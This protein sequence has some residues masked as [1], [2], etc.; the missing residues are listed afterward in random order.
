[1][2]ISKV[3]NLTE[4]SFVNYTG[5][6]PGF[7][8]KNIIFGY[9]GRGKSSLAAGIV[10]EFLKDSMNTVNNYRFFNRTFI[11]DNLILKESVN[12]RIRGVV[13]NF[14]E[15][16]VEIEKEIIDLEKQIVDI[17]E[18]VKEV[19]N[20]NKS[21]RAEIDR[22]HDLK[23]GKISIA[24]KAAAK[25]NREVIELYLEDLKNAKKIESDEEKIKS[26]KGDSSLEKD[27]YTIEKIR[28]PELNFPDREEVELVE[29]ILKKKFDD[30]EIPSS[31]IVEW[32]NQGVKMHENKEIC[33]FCGNNLDLNIIKNKVERYNNN[34]KQISAKILKGIYEKVKGLNEE[35]I[36]LISLKELLIKMIDCEDA[37][38]RIESTKDSLIDLE[39]IIREK[40]ENMDDVIDYDSDAGNRI[41]DN[42]YTFYKEILSKRDGKKAQIEIMISKLN[43]LIK[44]SIALEIKENTFINDNMK[45]VE[46][47]SIELQEIIKLNK[48][49]KQKIEELKKSKSN[50]KDF[51]DHITN[52]LKDL[53]INLKLDLEDDD[54]IIRHATSSNVLKLNEISEGEFNLLSLLYFYYELYED[55]EQKVL[56]DDIKLIIVDDPIASMDN[57]NRMYVL[58]L[59]K[60]LF[61]IKDVQLFVFTHVWEDFCDICYNKEDNQHTKFRLLEIKKESG[62]SSIVKAP[63]NESPYKHCFKEIYELSEKNNANDLN[64]CEIYHYP[65]I[66]RKVLEEYL[67][68]KAKSCSPTQNNSSTIERVLCGDNPSAK[69]KTEIGKLLNVC[70]ILSHRA[71]RNPDE[72]LN[73]A[74]FLMRRIKEKD[75]LHYDT[76]KE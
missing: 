73:S 35:I 65:N 23:K 56:K 4:K 54:Y 64:E 40:I 74:K 15:K 76:M 48:E 26:L 55:D 58:E 44:G 36:R 5:P 16:N 53:E 7:K 17:T 37:F 13:A 75:K 72:I 11:N 70:N 51:A 49:N 20:L 61:N 14:G 34:E 45:K 3:N 10:R 42:I 29:E 71:S 6:E 46:D 22:I 57:T 59:V 39:N 38:E 33:M 8:E 43:V 12:P 24:K 67:H 31:V 18:R 50:T 47:K 60:E 52:V 19:E 27:K 30:V 28:I 63:K 69:D 41:M 62:K 32:I 66:M 2:S 1:M 21:I 25:N 9:N 68:F